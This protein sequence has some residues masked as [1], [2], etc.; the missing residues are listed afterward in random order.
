MFLFVLGKFPRPFSKGRRFVSAKLRLFETN[1]V[2]GLCDLDVILII[3]NSQ[4]DFREDFKSPQKA[5]YI[6]IISI[7]KVY[8]Q[9]HF[10]RLVRFMYYKLYKQKIF[11]SSF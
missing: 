1:V 9:N 8:L 3:Y 2:C 6:S 5:L 10:V 11:L 7:Q 4:A